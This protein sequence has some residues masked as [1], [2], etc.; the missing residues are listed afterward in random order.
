MIAWCVA[1]VWPTVGPSDQRGSAPSSFLY[2][3][4]HVPE[5]VLP[6]P[7]VRDS[8]LEGERAVCVDD[9]TSPSWLNGAEAD[10]AT[11]AAERRATRQRWGVP[12][13][14]FWYISGHRYYGTTLVRHQLTPQLRHDGGHIGY[15]IVPRY[16]RRGYATAMLA[17]AC[18]LCRMDGMCELLVTC[19]EHNIGSRR[20]IEANNGMLHDVSDGI[21]HYWIPL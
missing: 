6:I 11:F 20:V 8:F 14:E 18:E 4:W 9:G 3:T 15:H 5:L 16:R 21:C 19:D 17:A 7:A 12:T 13:T 1:R 10:F 2:D